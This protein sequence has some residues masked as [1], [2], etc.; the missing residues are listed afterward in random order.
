VLGSIFFF[1]KSTE[2]LALWMFLI[3]SLQFFM[4]PTIRLARLFHLRR[5]G[6]G[7]DSSQDY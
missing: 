2:T 5:V 1:F 7:G 4:R 3:G 6:S